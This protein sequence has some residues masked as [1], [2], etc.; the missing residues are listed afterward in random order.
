MLNVMS[1]KKQ[2]LQKGEKAWQQTF[3]Q[4]WLRMD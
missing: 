1:M 2:I 4:A 3:Q